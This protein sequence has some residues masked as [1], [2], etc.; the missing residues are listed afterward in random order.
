MILTTTAVAFSSPISIASNPLN[1]LT[2]T[3]TNLD[4]IYLISRIYVDQILNLK[5]N[6]CENILFGESLYLFR[7]QGL[8]Q[9]FLVYARKRLQ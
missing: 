3:S 7:E 2:G 6:F 8:S 5:K 9:N 1:I 4:G